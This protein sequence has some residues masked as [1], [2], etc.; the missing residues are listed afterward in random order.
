[1]HKPGSGASDRPAI[2]SVTHSA[3]SVH[4]AGEYVTCRRF[5]FVLLEDVSQTADIWLDRRAFEHNTRP[6]GPGEHFEPYSARVDRAPA[7]LV[8]RRTVA[9]SA[10]RARAPRSAPHTRRVAAPA[11]R[12]GPRRATA[13]SRPMPASSR[14]SSIAGSTASNLERRR[15]PRRR[16]RQGRQ[17][18]A[19]A[20]HR[21]RRR[22]R[23]ASRSTAN[24]V[25]RLASLSK[26]FATAMAGAARAGRRHCA[27]TPRSPTCCR[28]SRWPMS[29][30][31][32][33]LTVARHPQPPRRPAAQ[34]LRPR[35]SKP[36][37]RTKRS[38]TRLAEVP[39]ACPVGDCYGY[40]NIAF[41]LIG[42]V[43]YRRHRR[44]LLSPGRDAHLPSARHGRPRPTAATRSKAPRAGRGRIVAPAAAGF[45]SCRSEAT[46][47]CRRRPASTPASATWSSG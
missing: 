33:K 9:R 17:G 41:S 27:G 22:E 29:P 38:S 30:A 45:R 15:R 6:Q 16:R 24:T 18:A 37:S 31:S 40:Q 47:T 5:A 36:T 4:R 44:F 26:A 12:Q 46:T 13:P 39:M 1:M 32:Q 20:R 34:H 21:L 28:R 23:R 11:V 42:D 3:D 43:T 25:F 14:A 2:C 8:L 7:A 10:P 19:R 35:C